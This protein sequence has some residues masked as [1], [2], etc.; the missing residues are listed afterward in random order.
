MVAIKGK[1]EGANRG[2]A[3]MANEYG[4]IVSSSCNT[5]RDVMLCYNSCVRN[6][7]VY[8]YNLNEHTL[9]VQDDMFCFNIRKNSDLTRKDVMQ[10]YN[11]GCDKKQSFDFKRSILHVGLT[12]VNVACVKVN[13]YIKGV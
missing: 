3:S 7:R 9:L 12:N 11:N 13:K 5:T 6:N 10:R 1:L 4:S 2:S 8:G